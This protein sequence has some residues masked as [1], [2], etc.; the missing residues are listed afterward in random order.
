MQRVFLCGLMMLRSIASFNRYYITI[1]FISCLLHFVVLEF[2]RLRIL[3]QFKALKTIT[4]F[5]REK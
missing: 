3:L 1:F 2:L 5:L 4:T